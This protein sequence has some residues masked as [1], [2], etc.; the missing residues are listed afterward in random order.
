[1]RISDCSPAL[2]LLLIASRRQSAKRHVDRADFILDLTVHK[3]KENRNKL[4]NN[5]TI[6][7][8][9]RENVSSGG[10]DGRVANTKGAD[11]PVHLRS[12]ISAFGIRSLSSKLATRKFSVF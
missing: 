6:L 4:T 10:G 5:S 1:M 11:Q 9:T 8:S 7:A 2:T 3:R 12:L